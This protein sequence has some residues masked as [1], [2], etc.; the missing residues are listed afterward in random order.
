MALYVGHQL[1]FD[2]YCLLTMC[3]PL[4]TLKGAFTSSKVILKAAYDH[5]REYLGDDFVSQCC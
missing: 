1:L 2:V 3:V 5:V 4:L